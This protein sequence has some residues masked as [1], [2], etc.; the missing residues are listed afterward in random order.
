MYFVSRQ[1]YL[2]GTPVVEIATGGIESSNPDMLVEKY[3]GEGKEYRDPRR[4]VEVAINICRAWRHDGEKKAKIAIGD[5]LG[6]TMP[7]EPVS[8]TEAKKWAQ[9]EGG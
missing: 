4:A 1:K 7:F 2:D 6:A 9:K 8:F 3:E 5:T